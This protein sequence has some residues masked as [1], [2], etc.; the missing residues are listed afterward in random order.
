MIILLGSGLRFYD[1]GKENL[2][3]DEAF[4]V[5][6]AQEENLTSLVE[7]TAKT[8]G[9]PIGY[10]L[11]LHYWVEI[12]G[13]S[14]FSVR[15]PSLIFS[16][17]SIF[18][19]FNLTK[20]FFNR[21]V[22][23][24]TSFFMAISMLQVLY[25]Q[26]ARLYSLFTFL[27]LLSAYFFS[28]WYL[29]EKEDKKSTL[30]CI[31]YGFSI[32]TAIYTNYLAI[33]LIIIYTFILIVKRDISKKRLKKWILIHL[34]TFIF[35]LPLIPLLLK[36][37]HSINTRLPEILIKKG[38]P[39]FLAKTGIFF[40][41][42]PFILILFV[43]FSFYIFRRELKGIF[44]KINLRDDFFVLIVLFF[45]L[46]YIY[47]TKYNM[48]IFG[49]N[50]IPQSI[51]HSYFL[52]RHSFFLAPIIYVYFAYKI[53][54]LNSKKWAFFCLILLIFTNFFALAMYYN[55]ATKAE[56]GKAISYIELK[57]FHPVILLDKG[58]FSNVYLLE[59]YSTKP[60]EI[61][62]LTWSDISKGGN[63]KQINLKDLSN[64][65]KQNKDFWL[66]LAR[67][68]SDYYKKDLDEKYKLIDEKKFYEI[69][70]YHYKVS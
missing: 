45:S 68:H 70:L 12:F 6:L 17:L 44:F 40:F 53:V 31:G 49:I 62:N 7:N 57:S 28:K 4:S 38:M 8:E 60:K 65:L 29:Y 22:A 19:I 50:I 47:L 20:L 2:W 35:F 5:H 26:E 69:S 9:T 67:G 34:I 46:L 58:G 43:L 55:T 16:V 25:S 10:Y 61:I 23:L 30:Y 66:I 41:T 18:M 59:Y 27:T 32:L 1:L 39:F 36:Q 14:E 13:N 51:T 37:Y 64:I 3:T 42:I 15:F 48:S 24:L 11:L 33:F 21:K 52:I 56:W 54:S 63:L